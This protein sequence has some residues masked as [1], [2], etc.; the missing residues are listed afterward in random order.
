MARSDDAQGGHAA[1][2]L[3]IKIL[4]PVLIGL[5]VVYVIFRREF[6]VGAIMSVPWT[7]RSAIAMLLAALAVYG[8][9]A[10]MAWRFRV[11]TDGALT[12]MASWRVTMLCE[13]TSAITPT[14]VGGSALSMIFLTREGISAGRSTALTMTTLLLD[15]MFF[16]LFV[17]VVMLAIPHAMLFGF[18]STI[19]LSMGLETLFWIIYG[20]MA[21]WAG[22]LMLAIFYIP[23]TIRGMLVRL[24]GLRLL[25]RWQPAVTEMG[26]SLVTTSRDIRHKPVGWWMRAFGATTLSWVSRYLVVNALFFGFVYG[27]SQ[28]VVFGRQFVVWALLMFS[29]TPGGSGLSEFLFKE[30]YGDIITGAATL[31]VV[32]LLWRVFTYYIYLMIGIG[33]IPSYLKLTSKNERK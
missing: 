28:V 6:S 5:A 1:A 13:F 26:D 19:S 2:R 16:V 30:Y 20:A 23:A 7:W 9:D 31:M 17:P 14:S 11:L 24:F 18:D 33:M 15:Q 32:S 3:W 27:A 21:V 8:R 25:R 10:G 22:V 12:R 4:L 29:P